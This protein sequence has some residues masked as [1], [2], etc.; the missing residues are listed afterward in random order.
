MKK[1]QIRTKRIIALA[2]VTFFSLCANVLATIA[3]FTANREANN[4]HSYFA[5]EEVGDAA[6]ESVNIYKFKYGTTDFTIGGN[7]YTTVDYLTPET[8]EVKKYGFDQTRQKFGETVN[9]N[10]EEVTVMNIYDPIDKIIQQENFNLFTL[11]CNVI[12]EIT[13][14]STKITNCT[15]DVVSKLL[16]KTPGEHQILLSDCVD[17]DVFYDEDLT[18]SRLNNKA[19]YPTYKEDLIAS[20]DDPEDELTAEEILYYK[21]SY[22]SSLMATNAH[23]HFY[24][25][26]PKPASLDL[27]TGKSISFD[28]NGKF[29][30]YIN[31]NYQ[32]NELQRYS[33]DIYLN[34]ILAIYDFNFVTKFNEE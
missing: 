5:V 13:F 12:Y 4:E 21:F 9:G 30:F 15:M 6:I 32:P 10:F 14:Y 26:N 34:N 19:Y 33:E 24:G 27:E 7:T 2:S 3:W 16:T 8:G 25:S 29:K 17:F 22:L 20:G 11:N 31:A 23:S 18:D 1:G 28:A